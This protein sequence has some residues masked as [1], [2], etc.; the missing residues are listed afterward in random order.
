M[1]AAAAAGM[2]AGTVLRIRIEE[3]TKMHRSGC[4]CEQVLTLEDKQRIGSVLA[5]DPGQLHKYASD[6]CD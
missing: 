3:F 6:A 5:T 1:P 2:L 4:V